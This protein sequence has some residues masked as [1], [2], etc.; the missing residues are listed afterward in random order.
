MALLSVGVTAQQ[1]CLTI[2]AIRRSKHELPEE[3]RL[4]TRLR[5]A[6]GNRR[7]HEPRRRL[8]C[9]SVHPPQLIRHSVL[10]LTKTLETD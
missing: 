10:L 7:A 6:E 1:E 2:L 8:A 3:H 4:E 5:S 9:E